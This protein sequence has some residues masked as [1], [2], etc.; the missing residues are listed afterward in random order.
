VQ[1]L[2]MLLI[3]A[4]LLALPAAATHRG[5]L[6]AALG[7][8]VLAKL[9]ELA[10]GPIHAALGGIG[11]HPLKHLASAAAVAMLARYLRLRARDA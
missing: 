7:T 10:D 4:M 11:G 8:Y 3:P 6:W 5:T 9:L 2:P 1:F